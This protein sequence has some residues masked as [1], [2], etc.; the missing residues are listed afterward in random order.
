MIELL[1]DYIMLVTGFIQGYSISTYITNTIDS[2]IPYIQMFFA[3]L[4]IFLFICIG[5]A[6]FVNKGMR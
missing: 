2:Y 4:G 1:G 3:L 5:T 6:G